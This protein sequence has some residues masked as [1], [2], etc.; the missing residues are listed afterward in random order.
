MMS[1]F[2][3][4]LPTGG[5]KPEGFH[6]TELP[7]GGVTSII[8]GDGVSAD[9]ATGTVTVSLASQSYTTAQLLALSNS[10]SSLIRIANCSDCISTSPNSAFGYGDL[11]IWINTQNRWVTAH[12]KAP[13]TTD[14]MVW[15]LHA[16]RRDQGQISTPFC[17]ITG[18]TPTNIASISGFVTGTGA[19]IDTPGSS[20]ESMNTHTSAVAA[21]NSVVRA[22]PIFRSNAAFGTA[23]QRAQAIVMSM[24]SNAA[25]VSNATD[26][27]QWRLGIETYNGSA[28][29]GAQ[30][31]MIS[32]VMDDYDSLGYGILNSN[33]HAL[34]RA[35]ST[36]LSVVD[37]GIS[38]ASFGFLV[39]T[40]EPVGPASGYGRARVATANNY[41]A[42]ITT[43]L[44]SLVTLGTITNLQ[45]VLCGIKNLG[46]ASRSVSRKWLRSVAL[47][48]NNTPGVIS[49]S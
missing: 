24:V 21:L 33:L 31:D 22:T 48:T 40:W 2:Q 36:T 45:G 12:D 28:V 27:W 43:H 23:P 17:T 35:N 11:A 49:V 47:T 38:A 29:A 7:E 26:R 1:A 41:G 46:A 20:S 8:A 16:C 30:V 9:Q 37:T 3:N 19:V 15:S 32:L 6:V 42:I 4:V 5:H 34:I 39:V 10:A 25:A 44:D 13:L 18:E 14:F